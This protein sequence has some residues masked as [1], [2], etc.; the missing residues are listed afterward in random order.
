[1]DALRS[2]A[3]Q[4]AFVVVDCPPSL[5]LLTLNALVASDAAVIPCSAN[6]MRWRG[7]RSS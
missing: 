1:M 2:V 7:W 3:D 5:G 6:T 4:F